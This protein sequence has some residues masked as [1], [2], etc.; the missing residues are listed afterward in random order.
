VFNEEHL[1][2]ALVVQTILAFALLTVRNEPRPATLTFLKF[3]FAVRT[4][5]T[6]LEDPFLTVWT[7]NGV[8][9]L[10]AVWTPVVPEEDLAATV[11][12]VLLFVAFATARTVFFVN[13]HLFRNDNLAE[14][15]LRNLFLARGALIEPLVNRGILIELTAFSGTL[16]GFQFL[17]TM[18]TGIQVSDDLSLAVRTLRLVEI[19]TTLWAREVLRTIFMVHRRDPVLTVRTLLNFFFAIR[20]F[21][22]PLIEGE[23]VVSPTVFMRTRDVAHLLLT[24][25]TLRQICGNLSLAVRTLCQEEELVA[26]LAILRVFV[27]VT[28]NLGN[29]RMTVRAFLDFFFTEG[30]FF[31]SLV[32]GKVILSLA[33][34]VRTCDQGQ[35]A[36]AVRTLFEI[37]GDDHVTLW[38]LGLVEVL[39]AA[40]TQL[41]RVV[42]VDTS[43]IPCPTVRTLKQV[44]FAVRTSTVFLNQ[45]KRNFFPA[46]RT[47]NH[48]T[49]GLDDRL[50]LHH[51]NL[52]T[53]LYQL[54]MAVRTLFVLGVDSL[55]AAGT[56]LNT[57]FVQAGFT[58]L[59]RAQ[60]DG[61]AL[62]TSADLD[63]TVCGLHSEAI[64]QNE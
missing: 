55:A 52:L 20:T 5:G 19:L 31:Q 13:Y 38:A 8:E 27:L 1:C 50:N 56:H 49:L 62:G 61:H 46:I 54:V 23:V 6:T 60:I 29:P 37:R 26:L 41:I 21:F 53:C 22:Q 58:P 43:H 14:D 42:A 9:R 34:F 7:L 18:R 47:A 4:Q 24:A 10:L 44:C 51:R 35:F 59:L 17:L 15:A 28:I 11:W 36:L 40:T 48:C 33:V 45:M 3:H 16:N 63:L 25:R 2:F 39:V 32:E 64:D 12:T 57:E 30:T